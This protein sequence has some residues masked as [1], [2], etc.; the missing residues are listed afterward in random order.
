[1]KKFT[2]LLTLGLF[3]IVLAAAPVVTIRSTPHP[4][5]S[6]R[7]PTTARRRK[8]GTE[9]RPDTQDVSLSR[10]AIAPLMLRST[11]AANMLPRSSS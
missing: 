3:S 4:T 5:R 9:L 6:A 2:K 7:R 11:T 10:P 1:M 8:K